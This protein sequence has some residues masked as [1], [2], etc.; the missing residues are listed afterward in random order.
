MERKGGKNGEEGQHK[1]AAGDER[2]RKKLKE[3]VN[4]VKTKGRGKLRG[5]SI[6]KGRIK[7]D[8]KMEEGKKG[9]IA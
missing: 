5:R 6:V 1:G 2:M 4:N 7:K 8:G 9:S 3:Y